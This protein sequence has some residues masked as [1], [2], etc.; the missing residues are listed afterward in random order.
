MRTRRRRPQER[1]SRKSVR[2]RIAATTAACGTCHI[3]Y[4]LTE[5]GH[6]PI[7]Y[8]AMPSIEILEAK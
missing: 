8:V 2:G 1:A 7:V 4:S 3:L 6:V 5:D